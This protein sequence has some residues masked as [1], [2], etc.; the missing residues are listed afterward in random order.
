MENKNSLNITS[1]KWFYSYSDI[2]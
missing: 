2:S 1:G